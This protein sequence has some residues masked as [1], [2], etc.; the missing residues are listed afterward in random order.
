MSKVALIT[1]A[2]GGIG[3]AI[4]LAF[5]KAGYAVAI[6][7]FSNPNKALEL[8]N[9]CL[10]NGSKAEIFQADLSSTEDSKKLIEDIT[11][12]LGPVEVLVNN[13]GITKDQLFMRMSE[14][15]FWQVIQ[16][17]LGSVYNL[18]K[19]VIRSMIKNES[20][21]IINIS[22][23]VATLGNPGQV[24]YVSSKAAIEGFT[25]ALAKEVAKK[26]I[27]VNAVAPGFIETEMT[28]GLPDDIKQYYFNQIPMQRF[29]TPEDIAE[30]VLFLATEASYMTGQILHVNGGM[31]G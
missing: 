26:G 24:N 10:K 11:A 23:V 17:N 5:S 2:T 3:K 31:I 8:K 30:V 16:T 9:A 7:T 1:G 27:T 20:G 14:E 29:G 19:S 25:K 28:S 21:R 6:H 12:S 15:D 13:A 4:T 22:S 18:S